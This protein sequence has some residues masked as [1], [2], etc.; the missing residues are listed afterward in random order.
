M[1]CAYPTSHSLDRRLE[2]R[3]EEE[4][5]KKFGYYPSDLSPH[6]NKK[7]LA[8]CD[9]CGK[10]RVTSKNY[11]CGL[12]SSCC[13]KGK[14]S[15]NWRGGKVK[16]I[17]EFCGAEFRI[18]ASVIRIGK[19]RFCSKKCYV[20]SIRKRSM[21]ELNTDLV[22][23]RVKRVC[24]ICSKE[25]FVTASIARRGLGRFCSQKCYGVLVSRTLKG[26]KS[27]W[28][29]GGKVKRICEQCGTEFLTKHCLVKVGKGKFCSSSCAKKAL[30]KREKRICNQCGKEFEVM[31]CVIKT[32]RGKFCSKVC[33][34][35]SRR[36]PRHRTKPERIFDAI[37]K[38]NDFPYKYTGDG[39]FWIG[40]KPSINPDF[41]ECNGKKIAIEI[42]SY[43]HDPLRRFGKV[44]YS[45]TYEGRKKIL[46]KYGWKL[47]VFWQEDLERKDAKA[48]VLSEL[49]KYGALSLKG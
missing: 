11:Y 37:C 36:F 33:A 2:M 25:F 29:K 24:E 17:C 10:V 43:W 48:F 7:I 4:T 31:S 15:H 42:F 27:L 20:E 44:R 49:Q 32:G 26:E 21:E 23:G 45:G 14:N 35:K 18:T 34:R 8:A 40:K 41:V 5:F 22:G 3:L 6:S 46:K 28:W 13:R 30:K 1:G 12:C 39:S 47:I 9:D 38:R 16:R 19:G